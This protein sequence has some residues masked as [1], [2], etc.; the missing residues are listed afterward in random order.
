MR[1]VKKRKGF[2]GEKIARVFLENKGYKIL[3][4]NW[5]CRW[6][7]I[8][9]IAQNQ[10]TICFIEVKFRT[11]TK[12]GYGTESV[13]YKKR[14]AQKRAINIYLAEN[15]MFNKRHNF[16]VVSILKTDNKCKIKH[17]KSVSLPA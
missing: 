16:E 15:K 9:I 11:S 6:G 3:Y 7:E 17:Y 5:T 10:N 8:D 14:L 13:N 4:T 12:Y 2:L 1:G